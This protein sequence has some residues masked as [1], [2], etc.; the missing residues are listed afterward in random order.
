MENWRYTVSQC[1]L[2]LLLCPL[3]VIPALEDAQILTIAMCF[4]HGIEFTRSSD[5]L[6]MLG[7][8]GDQPTSLVLGESGVGYKVSVG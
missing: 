7:A 5:Y 2:A 1:W 3:R 6:A 4:T 8:S